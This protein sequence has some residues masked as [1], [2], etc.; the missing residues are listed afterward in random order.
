MYIYIYIYD[1][2]IYTYI[3]TYIYAEELGVLS[4]RAGELVALY[5]AS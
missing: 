2:Y 3:H 4:L 5:I 1:T